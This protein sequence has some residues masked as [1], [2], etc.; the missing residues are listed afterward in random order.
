MCP[1]RAYPVKKISLHVLHLNSDSSSSFATCFPL[2]FFY[3][4]DNDFGTSLEGGFLMIFFVLKVSNW[5]LGCG[6]NYRWVCYL[7]CLL[8]T[9]SE[10]EKSSSSSLSNS[11]SLSL[12]SSS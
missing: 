10:S 9:N 5:N 12:S 4:F 11:L 6:C 8:S 1:P 7:L 3:L 2:L